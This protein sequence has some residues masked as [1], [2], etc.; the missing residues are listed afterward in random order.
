MVIL[1]VYHAASITIR[2]SKWERWC[3]FEIV[4]EMVGK[5]TN[6]L[7]VGLGHTES[8]KTLEKVFIV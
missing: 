2:I 8:K 4:Q 7:H 3:F 5:V 1:E 6:L